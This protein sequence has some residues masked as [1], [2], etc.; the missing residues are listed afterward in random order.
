MQCTE[1]W[2]VAVTA[3]HDER[4]SGQVFPCPSNPS[5]WL[6]MQ[7]LMSVKIE[8]NET[9][10]TKSIRHIYDFSTQAE[11]PNL[12]DVMHDQTEGPQM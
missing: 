8:R 12:I 11:I 10:A 1:L 9:E 3:V 5:F 4:M 7:W 2:T 6:A